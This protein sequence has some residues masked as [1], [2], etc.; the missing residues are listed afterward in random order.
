M[1]LSPQ[2]RA[3][4]D[5]GGYWKAMDIDSPSSQDLESFGKRS[6]SKWLWKGFGFLFGEILKYPITLGLLHDATQIDIIVNLPHIFLLL[7]HV[8]T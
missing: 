6:F 5:F 3:R 2:T 4:V 8:E 7:C 1:N